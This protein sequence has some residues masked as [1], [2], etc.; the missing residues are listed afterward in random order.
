MPNIEIHIPF[1]DGKPTRD[2][3]D[4]ETKIR[5]RVIN[6]SFSPMIVVSYTNTFSYMSQG[7]ESSTFIRIWATEESMISELV[8]AL[9][10]LGIDIETVKLAGFHQG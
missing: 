3:K 7:D 10:P 6:L 1:V 5:A 4:I 8:E 2:A 9:K